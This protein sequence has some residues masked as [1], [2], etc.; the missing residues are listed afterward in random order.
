MVEE[1]NLLLCKQAEHDAHSADKLRPLRSV[2]RFQLT[3]LACV[4]RSTL[5]KF[6]EDPST[7]M[8][9]RLH[10]RHL[11]WLRFQPIDKAPET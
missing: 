11:S 8:V 5:H 3:I 4:R 1:L 7:P 2:P 6:F 9:F 10:F